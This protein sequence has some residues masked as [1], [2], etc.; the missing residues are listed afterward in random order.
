[1]LHALR[2][3][4]LV[5]V[6]AVAPANASEWQIDGAARVVAVADIHGAFDA[7]VE[8]L[9]RS[10]VINDQQQ[11]SGADTHLVIVGDILDRG[12]KS[13]DAMD[14]LMQLEAAAESAGGAVHV[15]IGNH[16]SM[17]LIGDL[18]YVSKSEYEAFAGDETPEERQRWFEAYAKR[19]G[20]ETTEP[21][22]NT[23]FDRQFPPGFFALRRAFSPDGKYGKW[24][25]AKPVIVVVNGTAF[26]HG[27]LS[28]AI[29]DLGLDGVNRGLKNELVQYVTALQVL[30]NAQVLLP[31]D[32]YYDTET[33][34][35]GFMPALNETPAVLEAV[36][37]VQRLGQ[38]ELFDVDG[39][40]WYRGSVTCGGLI[41]EN[42]LEAAL[43]AIG[44]ERVVVG[45]T[46]TLN[47]RVLQRFN[48]RVIE[49]DTGML[50]AYYRGSGN[51]LVL[52]GDTV[53]VVN[54]SGETT[55]TLMAHPRNVGS[56]PRLMSPEELQR[57]LQEGEIVS[58]Q[59]D[60]SDRTIVKVNDG[61]TTF[62]AIFKKRQSRG[63]YPDV[64][65][66]RLDRMLELDMVPVTVV[67]E[68]DGTAGSLQFLAD[69]VSD[70][71]RRSASG[72]GGGA[73]CPLLD[74]WGAMYVFD[75]LIYNEGRSMQRMLYD[76]TSWRL[77]LS[78]HDRAFASKKGRPKHLQAV[79]L[80]ISPGWQEALAEL[81]DDAL[82]QRLDD[83]L[84]GRRLKALRARRDELLAS[85]AAK[86]ANR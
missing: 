12:P 39:P 27:G 24:L 77:M 65:A 37:T 80:D 31:T 45:H 68:V 21:D 53:A 10:G 43:D 47:R 51:A 25:L 84:D 42:R 56:R 35:N 60:E 26:V 6:A 58:M 8:T 54:Q 32:S 18:R 73:A 48:G 76:P 41:E 46:P 13:R 63:F 50:N 15:V 40:L 70:E 28:S 82:S 5:A 16:E 1:M 67:R 30:T 33:I 2:I 85:A 38:S 72:Q 61:R 20:A 69:K 9:Q 86:T 79:S 74:Q 44:A 52:E 19:R 29:P 23:K 81:S 64:A 14:L 11:W 78:E 7:M 62:A 17:N 49:I 36:A 3:C 57:V 22:L 71:M 34:L 75:V 66:Y 4:L 55:S 83:V 59:Q